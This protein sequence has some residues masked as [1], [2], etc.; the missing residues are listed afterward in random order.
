MIVFDYIEAPDKPTLLKS[1][2]IN[3]CFVLVLLLFLKA[4]CLHILSNLY[5]CML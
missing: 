4:G 1:S 2:G 5:K 3:T